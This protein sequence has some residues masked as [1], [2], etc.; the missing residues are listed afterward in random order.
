MYK[1]ILSRFIHMLYKVI[2]LITS[3]TLSSVHTYISIT[4]DCFYRS[5][6]VS[7]RAL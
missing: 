4:L 5:L 2:V 3:N 6:S 1:H 7:D